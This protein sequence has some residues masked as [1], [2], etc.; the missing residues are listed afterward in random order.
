MGDLSMELE[1]LEYELENDPEVMVIKNNHTH[2]Y[3]IIVIFQLY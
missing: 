3:P 1:A 2:D